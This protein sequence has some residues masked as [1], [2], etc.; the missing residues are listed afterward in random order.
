[1]FKVNL[2]AFM[3]NTDPTQDPVLEPYDVVFVPRS[4]IADVNLLVAQYL[5]ENIPYSFNY[6]LSRIAD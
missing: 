2:Q 5:R 3:E 6:D 4:R 1:M